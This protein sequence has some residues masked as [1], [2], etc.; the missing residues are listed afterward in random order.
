MS[1][2]WKSTISPAS[3]LTDKGSTIDAFIE[4]I[5]ALQA[6]NSTTLNYFDYSWDILILKQNLMIHI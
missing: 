4:R 1:K 3:S 2:A 5:W 6:L